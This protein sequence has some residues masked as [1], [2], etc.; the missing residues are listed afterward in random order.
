M[1]DELEAAGE[2]GRTT[3]E[4][5]SVVNL[6]MGRIEAMLK[7]LDVEGAV[8][9]A[10]NR[11]HAVPDSDWSYD[12]E[13]YAQ[14]TALRRAEQTAMAAYG[15]DGRCLMRVLQEEL[16]DPDPR[17]CGRCSV[18]TGPRFAQPPA[19]E[20][21]ELAQRHLRSRPLELEVQKMAPDAAT[22]AMRKI[23]EDART[24]PGWALARLGDGGWWPA[25]ERGLRAGRFDDEIA[26][27]LADIAARG[28]ARASHG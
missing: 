27:A 16:D 8:T 17:D 26:V 4:L 21:V 13:R 6:G 12:S 9:R 11:W 19:A 3:R 24:E 18:C 28:R 25:I 14:V 7:I 23:P 22:G 5:M 2:D 10:G 15:T 20:L 1:L